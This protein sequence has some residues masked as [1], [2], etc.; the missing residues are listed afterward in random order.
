MTIRQINNPVYEVICDRCGVS[1]VG[2]ETLP[3]HWRT[4]SMSWWPSPRLSNYPEHVNLCPGCWRAF[5]RVWPERF[6]S[7]ES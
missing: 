5:E 7:H 2:E 4:G 3:E 1:V 6:T